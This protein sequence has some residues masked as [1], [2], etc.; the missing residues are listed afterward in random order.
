MEGMLRAASV[1]FSKTRD[2]SVSEA[3]SGKGTWRRLRAK[4]TRLDR[5][6]SASVADPRGLFEVLRFHRSGQ[7]PLQIG[8]VEG[9]IERNALLRH[10]GKAP[11]MARGAV[12]FLKP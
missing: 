9:R 4:R 1:T 8:D 7:L 12:N 5:T 6:T 10:S 11:A 2:L 3:R